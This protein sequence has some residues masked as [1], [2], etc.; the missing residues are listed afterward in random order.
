MKITRYT[1]RLPETLQ[2]KIKYTATFNSRSKNKEIETAIKR[3]INDFERLYGII[4][5]NKE[6][7]A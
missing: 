6:D 7:K 5:C 3:Y 2:Q 1:L 4:D